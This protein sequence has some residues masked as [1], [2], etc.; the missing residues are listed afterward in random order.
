MCM[1]VCVHVCGYMHVCMCQNGCTH[2]CRGSG[3]TSGV[4][5]PQSLFSFKSLTEPWASWASHLALGI[6]CLCLPHVGFIGRSWDPTGPYLDSGCLNSSSHP[7]MAAHWII[8]SD[9]SFHSL[10]FSPPLFFTF[11]SLFFVRA[12]VRVC[13]TSI[14]F[15]TDRTSGQKLNRVMFELKTS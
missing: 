9:P 5:L 14:L 7:W 15:L 2:M 13:M 6:P 1:V 11:I 12:C 8:F 10:P 4:S 3:L